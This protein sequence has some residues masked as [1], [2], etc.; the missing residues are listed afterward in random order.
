[1]GTLQS[2]VDKLARSPEQAR[3]ENCRAWAC[4]VAQA[5]PIVEVTPRRQVKVAGIIR[6]IRI[7]PRSGSASIEATITDGTGEL[8]ARWLGRRPFTG[9]RLGR[10]LIVEGVAGLGDDGELVILNPEYR[11]AVGPEHP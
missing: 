6:N 2:L 5:T 10:G 11:V 8:V 9:M 1:M 3:A 7:D 4:T